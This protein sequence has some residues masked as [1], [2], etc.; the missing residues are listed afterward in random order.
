MNRD[1]RYRD[2]HRHSHR[3]CHWRHHRRVCHWVPNHR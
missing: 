3:V 2:H 1:E